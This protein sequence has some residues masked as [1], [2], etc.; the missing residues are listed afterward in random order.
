MCADSG[1]FLFE[2]GT[3]ICGSRPSGNER[4]EILHVVCFH[5]LP[6]ARGVVHQPDAPGAMG[7]SDDCDRWLLKNTQ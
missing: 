2:E 6:G 7:Q 3:T 5:S 4:R 1:T